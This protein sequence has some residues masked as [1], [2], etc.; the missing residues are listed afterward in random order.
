MCV[1]YEISLSENKKRKPA[2]YLHFSAF[3]DSRQLLAKVS[4]NI[5]KCYMSKEKITL[6]TFLAPVPISITENRIKGTT[7]T[8]LSMVLLAL[9][10]SKSSN[11][12]S[13]TPG[14][15]NVFLGT[16]FATSLHIIPILCSAIANVSSL[17]QLLTFSQDSL[18]K[19][20]NLTLKR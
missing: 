2:E 7:N 5:L 9:V 4:L 6:L 1:Q 12:T 15:I 20:F 3:R 17:L 18:R 11:V 13:V 10:T 14:E 8:G 16:S 19:I